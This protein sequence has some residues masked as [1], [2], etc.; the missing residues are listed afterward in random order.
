MG[1]VKNAL[2]ALM[3]FNV[4]SQGG[5]AFGLLVLFFYLQTSFSWSFA[6]PFGLGT[7]ADFQVTSPLGA[8]R[9]LAVF[10]SPIRTYAQRHSYILTVR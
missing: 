8:K 6:F 10:H 5:L 4:S 1:V 3:V 9:R 7:G 2:G